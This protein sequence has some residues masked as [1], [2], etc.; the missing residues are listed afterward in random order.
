MARAPAPPPK[1]GFSLTRAL[2]TLISVAITLAA[3]GAAGYLAYSEGWLEL[4]T[5]G[6]DAGVGTAVPAAT[7]GGVPADGDVVDAAVDD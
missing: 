4:P 1:E 7:D 2:G 3:L 5:V 6:A